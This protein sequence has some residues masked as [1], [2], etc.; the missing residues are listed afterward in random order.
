MSV[1]PYKK[2]KAKPGETWWL[3]DIG[4]G[5]DRVQV[6]FMGSFDEAKKTELTVRGETAQ[7]KT[8]GTVR[9]KDLVVPWLEWF[10]TEASP[11]TVRDVRF[12]IN[13]YLVPKF[14]HL[15][16]VALSAAVVNAF[17]AELLD[18]G[19]TPTT[20][21]K[22]LNY[23]GSMLRWAQQQNLAP[24][25]KI[26]KFPRKRCQPQEP[27]KPLTERMVSAILERL[28]GGYRLPFLLM[29]DQGLRLEEAL[30]L[31]VEDID[32]GRKVITVLGKGNKRRFVPFLSRRFEEALAA[33]MAGRY[34]GWLC[35]NPATGKPWS[36][37][38]KPIKR[39][40]ETAGITA[41]INHHILRHTC[42][43]SLAEAGM[44]PHALQA[45]LG[46]AS[47]ETTNKVY[48]NVR[49][50]WVGDEAREIMEKRGL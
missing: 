24:A 35:V 3:I 12:S 21:N 18:K 9:I 1:R 33:A 28:P 22:H 25:I 4:R 27:T 6:P 48:T 47:I 41:K 45:I 19:L 46:H 11:R 49:R 39:A 42:A 10:V 40:S 15:Q 32:Q 43:T 8:A 7:A 50:D 2:K 23:L 34:E 26:A 13:L 20:I 14:G 30:R 31:R 36:T 16:P 37:I 29:C 38:W 44:N 17:K 5:K